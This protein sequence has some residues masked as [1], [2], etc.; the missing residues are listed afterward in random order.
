MSIVVR[1]RKEISS[2]Q[3]SKEIGVTQ[4]TSWF[5][6][7][8]R[9]EACGGDYAKRVG[10]VE[11]DEACIGGKER[12]SAPANGTIPEAGRPARLKYLE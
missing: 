2:L 12:T 11:I 8:C 4:K 7:G 5:L 6:P 9:R 3:L 1:A 10:L